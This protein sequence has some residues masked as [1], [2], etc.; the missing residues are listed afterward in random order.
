MRK[1]ILFNCL[2]LI[3]L[4]VSAQKKWTGLGNDGLW[5]NQLNW[6]NQQLPTDED[7]VVLDNENLA[8]SYSVALPPTVVTIKYLTIMPASGNKIELDLPLEN[9]L[10][11][12]FQITGDGYGVTINAGGVLKNS[13]GA[14]SGYGLEISDSLKI[15][16]GGTYIHNTK[17]SNA[18]IVKML[19]RA[20]GTEKGVFVF[21]V[22]GTAGYTPSVTGRT[23]GSLVFSA[24]AAGRARSYTSTASSIVTV[25]GD[26]TF[27][28]NV[29]YSVNF[30]KDFVIEGDLVQ[31][32]GTFNVATKA[33]NNSI[34]IK[35][36]VRQNAAAVITQT[37]AGVATLE[38]CG[39]NEQHLSMFG[40]I[41]NSIALKV[42]ND[43][44]ISLDAPL[45]LP[46]E[47]NIAKGVIN[48]TNESLLTIE[49]GGVIRV[50]D[51]LQNYV[52][53]SIKK[54]G[55]SAEDFLFPVGK[56]GGQP[57]KLLGATGDV[58]VE[59]SS[60]ATAGIGTEKYPSI[61]IL[62]T[63]GYWTVEGSDGA[64]VRVQ[65]R[66]DNRIPDVEN[67]EIVVASF[68]NNQWINASPQPGVSVNGLLTSE[69]IAFS[70]EPKAITFGAFNVI[71]PLPIKFISRNAK[72][73][74]GHIIISWSIG[75]DEQPERFEIEGS[76]DGSTF[77]KLR[78]VVYISGL[79]V[80]RYNIASDAEYKYFRIKAFEKDNKVT[81][82]K[83]MFVAEESVPSTMIV[84][85]SAKLVKAKL[86]VPQSGTIQISI[87]S[88]AGTIV[89]KQNY[90]LEKGENSISINTSG[91]SCGT[92]LLIAEGAHFKHQA[93]TFIKQ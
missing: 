68:D 41:Q 90:F 55:L 50:S 84:Y 69:P 18:N 91:L 62:A 63:S 83:I 85:T 38:L 15:N 32:G 11:S 81:V 31:E 44:G 5:N 26:L 13:G 3:C 78:N 66:Y 86:Q 20:P 34:K 67:K 4:N 51:S 1:T 23:F 72:R 53:G 35:G 58:T 61:K 80:Y 82:D 71:T 49:N 16:N 14:T 2:L 21:D 29:S 27:T 60:G 43:N 92:Y 22:P 48:A 25:R 9:T 19:S 40:Q 77:V 54:E 73:E 87:Y 88:I 65:V 45:R 17:R 93:K 59:Y 89:E 37:S 76:A 47:L 52:N 46:F 39:T 7:S 36:N 33:N 79:S 10:S 64:N 56:N 24:N 57:L 30:S 74:D 12:A 70:P 6:T 75:N 28:G 8:G 42:N